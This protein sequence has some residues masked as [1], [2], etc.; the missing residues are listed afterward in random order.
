MSDDV[1]FATDNAL[2]RVPCPRRV[3]VPALARVPCPRRVSVPVPAH[4]PA[5]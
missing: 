5:R 2:A 3:S 1:L 4:I